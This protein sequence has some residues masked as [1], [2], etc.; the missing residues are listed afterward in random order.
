[1]LTT[2]EIHESSQITAADS[3]TTDAACCTTFYE[4]DLVREVLE[5][6]FHPGGQ[7]LTRRMLADLK[8]PMNALIADLGCGTG[9]SA[10]LIAAEHQYR[11]R[12][13]ERGASNVA[14]AEHRRREFGIEDTRLSFH[15]GD[16]SDL[17]FEDG[18]LDAILLECSFSLIDDQAAALRE[19][20]RVLRVDGV[21]GISDMSVEGTLP[22]DI[23]E[24]I[25][26]W[27][28]MLKAHSETGYQNIFE[29]GGFE[30][31]KQTDESA[32][33]L[34]MISA[35]KRKLVIFGAGMRTGTIKDL[36][37]DL[38]T[39]KYWLQRMQGEVEDRR[40]R[41]LGFILRRRSI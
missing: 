38:A 11:V 5:D 28:C 16:I 15:Q 27:T 34:T 23:L 6:I 41:Y 7:D 36:N 19:F 24:I 40:L 2:D 30:L 10:L 33:L 14:R 18:S 21:I 13:I 3:L 9:S 39:V 1:M 29:T 35:I 31:L 26:P 12:G 20:R 32:G 37:I 8:L 17:P 22:R 4:N 25:A